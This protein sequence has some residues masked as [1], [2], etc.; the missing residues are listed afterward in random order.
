MRPPIRLPVVAAAA[1]ACGLGTASLVGTTPVLAQAMQNPTMTNVIPSGGSFAVTGRIGDINPSARTLSVMREGK[2]PLP[3]VVPAAVDLGGLSKGDHVSIHYSRTVTFVVATP[4]AG[5][6]R[7]SETV[8]QAAQR[9]GG[10]GPEAQVIVGRVLKID[11]PGQFDIV[12]VNGGGVYTVHATD[13]SRVAALS[14]V[15][16]GDSVTVSIGPLTVTSLAR[17]NLFGLIC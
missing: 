6:P 15:K 8:S 14:A 2:D 11:G 1:L 9:P 5:T 16:A 7:A 10:I 13:P 17:C 3:M 4:D 12:N